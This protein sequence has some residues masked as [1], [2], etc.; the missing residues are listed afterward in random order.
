MARIAIPVVAGRAVGH[1]DRMIEVR[2]PTGDDWAQWREIRLGALA[3]AP[4]AYGSTHADWVDAPER[5]WRDRLD[6]PG[7]HNV[8][9]LLD[10]APAG[11]A[12]GIPTDAPDVAELISMYVCPAA[13]GHG[14]GDRLI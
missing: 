12:T 11:I 3:E 1:D 14:I 2:V 9:L 5:R 6:G 8:L 10:G 13:R 4:Y 7:Y